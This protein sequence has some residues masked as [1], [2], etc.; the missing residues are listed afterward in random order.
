LQGNFGA[1]NA[2]ATGE[3]QLV[4]REVPNA[5]VVL[6]FAAWRRKHCDCD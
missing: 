6:L 5:V 3:E 4:K 2:A 1:G